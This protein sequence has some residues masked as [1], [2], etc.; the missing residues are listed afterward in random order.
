MAFMNFTLIVICFSLILI[1]IG[2]AEPRIFRDIFQRFAD[3]PAGIVNGFMG[4]VDLIGNATRGIVSNTENILANAA[5]ILQGP[6]TQSLC[7]AKTVNTY[8]EMKSTSLNKLS[9]MLID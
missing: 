3:V 5:S 6:V 8:N 2:D 1:R 7:D 4:T 9:S